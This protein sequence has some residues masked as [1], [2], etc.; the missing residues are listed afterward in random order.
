MTQEEFV[1]F[2]E[3]QQ[4][5]ATDCP[6]LLGGGR[7]WWPFPCIDTNRP[8]LVRLNRNRDRE[9]MRWGKMSPDRRPVIIR[10]IQNGQYYVAVPRES[11]Y[12]PS[13]AEQL[14]RR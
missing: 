7:G 11:S 12:R 5:T 1:Q 3:A 8:R 4:L 6:I 9:M 13:R 10:P 14:G 2:A